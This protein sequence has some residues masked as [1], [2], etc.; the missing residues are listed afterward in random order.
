MIKHCLIKV[1]GQVQGVSFRYH[2]KQKADELGLTGYVRNNS[3]GSVGI[4]AEG[5]ADK[6]EQFIAWC[7]QGPRFGKVADVEYDVTDQV[8]NFTSFNIL[9]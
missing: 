3:D 1:L 7:R 4:E 5:E 8:R 2:A 6:L 9:P